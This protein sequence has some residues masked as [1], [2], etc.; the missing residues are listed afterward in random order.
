MESGVHN[1]QIYPTL[2]I[3]TNAINEIDDSFPKCGIQY[4]DP[5]GTGK[6]TDEAVVAGAD[7]ARTRS[8]V[9]LF[10]PQSADESWTE[11]VARL[12]SLEKRWTVETD[13]E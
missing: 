11:F 3:F 5:L 4:G 12:E 1:I 6:T 2:E 7:D 9:F 8:V 13:N 10:D